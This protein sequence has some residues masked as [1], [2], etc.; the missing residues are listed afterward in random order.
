MLNLT[1]RVFN[2]PDYRDE[3]VYISC[4]VAYV[5]NFTP[6]V[7][8]NFEHPPFAKYLIGLLSVFNIA[9]LAYLILGITSGVLL[10]LLIN[11]ISIGNG[12]LSGLAASILFLLDTIVFN[13][14]RFLLL[15]P[16]AI[17]LALLSIYLFQRGHKRSSALIGGLAIASKFSV[18]PIVAGLW[19]LILVKEKRIKD[20]LTYLALAFTTYLST[21]IMD[22]RLGWDGIIR[23]HVEMFEYMSWRHGFSPTIA[24]LGFMKLIARV[25]A[26]RYPGEFTIFI[27]TSG[28][29]VKLVNETFTPIGKWYLV[30]YIGGGSPLWYALLPS[31]LY[32]TYLVLTN[33]GSRGLDLSVLL[34]WLS[35][36]NVLAGPIDWYY[37]NTLPFLYMT[38]AILIQ[39]M[40]PRRYKWIL[41][42]LIAVHIASFTLTTLGVIPF[43]VVFVI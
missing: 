23:H 26:W 25:E 10:Y 3:E 28:S 15:D 18:V 41:L 38:L 16:P 33:R 1:V 8:C 17:F 27:S 14:H 40:T 6:P 19:L 30:L 31:L 35:L 20:S 29:I 9:R 5:T 42:S 7:L 2:L 37:V 32:A 34:S 39:Q 4:G 13:T 11:L 24:T 21:F 36:F 12:R 43:R 22:L